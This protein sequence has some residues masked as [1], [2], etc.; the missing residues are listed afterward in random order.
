MSYTR[1]RI[2]FLFD[3]PS[4][5]GPRIFRLVLDDCG[6][7]YAEALSEPVPSFPP[8]PAQHEEGGGVAIPAQTLYISST[9]H[10][11]CGFSV[12]YINL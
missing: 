4:Y 9:K 8:W 2:K 12:T 11:Y 5:M 7:I 10:I 1:I 3:Q 6:E